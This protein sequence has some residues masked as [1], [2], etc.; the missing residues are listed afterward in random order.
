[1]CD[2]VMEHLEKHE[3][4]QKIAHV[5]IIKL[6]KIYYKHDSIYTK[7]KEALKGKPEKL[8]DLYFMEKPTQEVVSAL[9]Q[10]VLIHGDRK[11]KIKATLL[12][13]YHLAIHNKFYEAKDLL[14][15]ARL[16]QII[17]KQQI[18]NQILYNRAIVQIGL[19]A[20][21]LGLFDDCNQILIDVCQSPKL[22]ESLAQGTSNFAR[23]QEKT[24]EEEIEEKKRYV[25]SHLH[26][27][28]EMLDCVYM[29]T[30]MF[31]EIPNLSQ[32]KTTIGKKVINRNFR[33]LI[34]QYD[35][36]GI[37]FVP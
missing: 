34:E 16:S 15:K 7:T 5:G 8:N 25:P 4:Q 1:M 36:K 27:N 13:V 30:S 11:M 33:K 3:D 29:T 17:A 14:M 24:L 20:F 9:V 28:L 37:Q 2:K 22:K 12:Q 32:N 31:L 26:V 6:D 21:R 18:S 19:S 23:Q 10:N 35:M